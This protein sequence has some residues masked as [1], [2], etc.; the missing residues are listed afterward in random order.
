MK[1]AYSRMKYILLFAFLIFI[2][3]NTKA[4]AF[5]LD[6]TF[7]VNFNFYFMGS[8]A[9]INGLNFEPDGKLMVYGYFHDDNFVSDVLRINED[10]NIDNTWNYPIGDGVEFFERINN[11]YIV[12][13][14]FM[15]YKINYYGQSTDSVW[16]HNIGR[17]NKCGIF[18][19]PYIF[20]DGSMFVGTDTCNY[21]DNK[22]RFFKKFFS[23]GSMDTNFSHKT[24]AP[25]F[26]IKKYSTDKLLLY[27]GGQNGFTKYDNIPANVMCRIDTLGNLDTTFKSIFVSGYSSP[28]PY[29]IQNDGKIIVVGGFYINNNNQFLTMIRLNPDGSLDSTF[30]NFNNVDCNLY[31]WINTICPSTDN[32]YII[33]GGF[34]QYQGYG[35]NAICKTDI[36]GFIDTNYFAGLGIDS[37]YLNSSV[38]P[39]VNCIKKD[40]NDT[41]YV[42]GWF[43]YY[44]GVH[45]NP[46][47]RLK[48]ISAGINE[49][50]QEKG[51]IKVYPNPTKDNLT[52]ETNSN[53]EQRLEITNLIGQTVYTIY[54]NKKAT[55]NTSAFANGVYILKLSSDKETVV[56]KF[57]KE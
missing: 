36:N 38:L 53:K 22:T 27:G 2:N 16:G 40:T 45:V 54:I 49:I 11:D 23:D 12:K 29:Y 39:H 24:N 25:V 30:N 56:R 4:Q 5:S 42:M 34:K 10:G 19:N 14:L 47:I 13:S 41:Y 33:G 26:G 35:R 6:T 55:I 8:G 57:V 28:I 46:I 9:T 48:G 31:Y 44:N 52:I 17:D 21:P 50:K 3:S 18:Y 51:M 43:T 15:L 20:T 37:V 32:G 7:H 1:K